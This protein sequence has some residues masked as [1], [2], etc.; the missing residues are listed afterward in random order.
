MHPLWWLPIN[1]CHPRCTAMTSFDGGDWPVHSLMLSFHDLRGLPLRR[2]PSTVPCSM[3]LQKAAGNPIKWPEWHNVHYWHAVVKCMS[4]IHNYTLYYADGFQNGP[5]ENLRSK[6][7]VDR[8]KKL[9]RGR[10]RAI[11]NNHL[12]WHLKCQHKSAGLVTTHIIA[13]HPLCNPQRQR[14]GL[15]YITLGGMIR[16]DVKVQVIRTKNCIHCAR[17]SEW[18]CEDSEIVMVESEWVVVYWR[19]NSKRLVAPGCCRKITRC[20]QFKVMPRTTW[21]EWRRFD[22]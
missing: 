6:G 5:V 19:F 18:W 21:Y 1:F 15:N 20:R 3:V 7:Q 17:D 16:D 9:R 13:H 8:I 10:E 14:V 2:P 4:Q 12:W 22:S 11:V